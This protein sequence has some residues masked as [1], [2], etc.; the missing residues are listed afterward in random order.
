MMEEYVSAEG[1]GQRALA[2]LSA[3]WRI[4]LLARLDGR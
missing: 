3:S 2:A 4:V 1:K